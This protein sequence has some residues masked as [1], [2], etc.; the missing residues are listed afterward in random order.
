MDPALQDAI[1]RYKASSAWAEKLLILIEICQIMAQ[2]VPGF[3]CPFGG[4][5]EPTE[6]W[7]DGWVDGIEATYGPKG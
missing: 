2:I 3:I 1:N 5:T 4:E 7:S 6:E